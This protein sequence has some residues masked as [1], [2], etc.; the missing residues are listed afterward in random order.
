LPPF[1]ISDSC[2]SVQISSWIDL[3]KLICPPNSLW[4]LVQ[5]KH[6]RIPLLIRSPLWFCSSTIKTLCVVL[7]FGLEYIEKILNEF[8]LFIHICLIIINKWKLNLLL[9]I[10]SIYTHFNTTNTFEDQ[11]N[12]IF[13]SKVSDFEVAYHLYSDGCKIMMRHNHQF[14]I[15]VS[16]I[17]F[18]ILE[19]IFSICGSF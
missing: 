10:S 2:L 1:Y 15:N 13:S 6:I 7:R 14:A 19:K 9:K 3:T 18:N 8:L 17:K 4:T 16:F 12:P 5:L 11:I